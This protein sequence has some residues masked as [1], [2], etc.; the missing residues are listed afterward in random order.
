[1]KTILL[2]G[3]SAICWLGYQP[4]GL[5]VHTEFKNPSFEHPIKKEGLFPDGWSSKTP[6]CTPDIIPG[7][8]GIKFEP[9]DGSTCVGLVTRESGSTENLG[10]ALAAPLEK[11]QCYSFSIQLA[12][13][14]SYVGYNQPVRLRV[15]GGQ[16]V[17]Q[18]QELLAA[19][20]LISHKNWKE[21]SF[22]LEPKQKV[23][24]ITLEAWYAPGTSAK[25]KGNILL[26]QCSPIYKC[27]KA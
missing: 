19:T 9:K 12:H 10:Q 17:G 6:E 23:Y 24:C 2:L 16:K 20:G 21:Y 25:Y 14:N 1:M 8:W 4:G 3:L 27:E 26:D 7:G 18:K 5:E 22:Q 11:G 15:W 13:T